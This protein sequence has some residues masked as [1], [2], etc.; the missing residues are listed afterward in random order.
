MSSCLYDEKGYV[1]K[2]EISQTVNLKNEGLAED[3]RELGV[4]FRYIGA[5]GADKTENGEIKY[6]KDQYVIRCLS[7]PFTEEWS[8]RYIW[9]FYGAEPEG[10]WVGKAGSVNIKDSTIREKGLELR[11][12]VPDFIAKLSPVM[13]V[14]VDDELLREFKLETAGEFNEVLDV[15]GIGTDE[16]KYLQECHRILKILLKDFDRVCQKYHLRY[17]LICGSLL[18]V[19][20]HKNMIPWDDDVDVAMPR[21]DFNE[22]LKHVEEEWGANS[23][24]MF[25]N[26][27]E[28]GNHSFL[29]Y[30]T[31][32]IY[33]KEEIPINVFRK[34]Q[35]KGR[36]DI[37]NHLPMDIY[38]LD[39]A[40]DNETLHQ[41][42]TQLIRG[43]YGLGMGHRAYIKESD[44]AN[45]DEKTQ[46]IV[47]VLS[48]M[49]KIIPLSWI[50]FFYEWIRRWNEKKDT[51]DYFQSNGFIYCIPW[52]LKQEWF[53]EG[54]RMEVEDFSVMIP[55]DHEA[56]L[57][58]Q[59]GDFAQFPPMEV[60]KPTH[61]EEASGIF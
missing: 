54:V 8:E 37:A 6:E 13:K 24:I 23:D 26:Y 31:R 48:G 34:I 41:I 42:Q 17:Y 46:R 19:V 40:S 49:G 36:S 7:F 15:S 4:F 14:Y 21:K 27:N 9:G 43:L 60:R 35:G 50:F 29:D 30:M 12:H 28:M 51:K 39:K 5:P 61:S 22:L 18:G 2:I 53:D 45:R 47:K 33:M 52:R 25:V 57:K 58:V 38:V 11:Y 16:Q 32:I 44:Y 3:A 55:K 56:Y 59:Y 10:T 20:R 1:V